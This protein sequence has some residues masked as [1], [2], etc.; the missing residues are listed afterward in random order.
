MIRINYKSIIAIVAAGAIVA[1]CSKVTDKNFLDKTD[2]GTLNEATVFAD[3]ALTFQYL[4]GI[5]YDLSRCYYMDN[6]VYGGGMWSF[7][8]ATDDAELV[9]SGTTAQASPAFN[10]ATFSGGAD[11][12]RFRN[13]WSSCYTNIRRVNVFIGNIANTPLSPAKKTRLI[14]EARFM[15]AYYYYHLLRNYGGVP[16]L[17]DRLFTLTDD[18]NMPR[19][20]FVETVDYIS[21]ELDEAGAALPQEHLIEDFGRPAKGAAMALKAR[22]LLLVAS[23][24]FNGENPATPA[25]VKKLTGYENYDGD[26]WKLAADANKAVMDLNQYSLVEDNATVP[27]YGF[28]RATTERRND[29]QIFVI[30]IPPG[31]AGSGRW[32]ENMLLPQTRGGQAYSYPTQELI[33]AFP[34]ANGKKIADA[35]SGYDETMPYNNRD[36]RFYYTILYNGAKWLDKTSNTKKEVWLYNQ[37]PGDGLGTSGNTRTGYLVR[38]LCNE[39]SGGNFGVAPNL[40]LVSIRYA[41]ILLN[42]AEALNEFQGPSTEVYQAVEAIRKRAGLN[43][44]QLDAGLTKEQMRD[45]IRNERRVELAFEEANRFYDIKRWH[46][47]HDLINGEMHGMRWTRVGTTNT[48]TNS[49]F[50]FETRKFLNPQMYYF[51]IPQSEINKSA[52]LVQNPGW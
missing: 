47:A 12:S 1:G 13:H 42:Y 21:K 7:S 8:E 24:L 31:V 44:Y 39:N 2:V 22:M 28:Y 9:W 17:G 50:T 37:A 40:G 23:P 45:I 46:I 51:P 3:S 38:K 6:G 20:S 26:R 30:S 49:R 48:F 35:G 5:Y 10:L 15:R 33:D 14:A 16:L 36:P 43:P 41:E 25:G 19:N 4:N 11:Y 52:D 34:M 18:F 29:E 32:F 27:G